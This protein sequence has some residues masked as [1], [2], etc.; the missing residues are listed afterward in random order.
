MEVRSLFNQ[1]QEIII[2]LLHIHCFQR[3]RASQQFAKLIDGLRGLAVSSHDLHQQQ[4]TMMKDG[5]PT[6]DPRVVIGLAELAA[7]QQ[8]HRDEKTFLP[9]P[10]LGDLV[11][12]TTDTNNMMDERVADD[13]KKDTLKF[14]RNAIAPAPNTL[15]PLIHS[16]APLSRLPLVAFGPTTLGIGTDDSNSGAIGSTPN[17]M[18]GND[19]T[20]INNGDIHRFASGQ[21]ILQSHQLN[22]LDIAT[23]DLPTPLGRSDGT[24]HDAKLPIDDCKW[25]Q[26][27]SS[28]SV[29]TNVT[30]TP[31]PLTALHAADEVLA[32][33]RRKNLLPPVQSGGASY[34]TTS[35]NASSST[36]MFT[37]KH[38]NNNKPPLH[39]NNDTTVLFGMVNESQSS[40]PQLSVAVES[41]H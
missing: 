4:P 12:D 36:H 26:I 37:A 41:S 8:R 39:N 6:T 14:G 10:I 11:S 21:S 5:S 40:Q 3:F 13:R 31:I 16:D 28:A 30:Q 35:S 19:T 15:H 2:N 9:P 38:H 25:R 17:I 34:T 27:T 20:M 7:A 33:L 24:E 1:C 29:T 32:S 23:N 18:I 22:N